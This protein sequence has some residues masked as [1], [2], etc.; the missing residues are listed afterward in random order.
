MSDE[1]RVVVDKAE[2]AIDNRA[3]LRRFGKYGMAASVAAASALMMI[4]LFARA[5]TPCLIGVV[6]PVVFFA[7]LVMFAVGMRS[8]AQ[9]A[10]PGVVS[11]I[12]DQV[13]IVRWR[14][15]TTIPISDLLHGYVE[16]NE[17]VLTRRGGDEITI[18]TPDAATAEALLA[19][20]G[21]RPSERVLR[22]PL[23][24]ASE[25]VLGS[26]ALGVISLLLLVPSFLFGAVV[27]GIGVQDMMRNFTSASF[28]GMSMISVTEVLLGA[29]I[30]AVAKLMSAR[31]AVVGTD[32]VAYERTFSRQFVPYS[33]IKAVEKDSQGVRLQ[34]EGGGSLLLPVTARG[35]RLRIDVPDEQLAGEEVRRRRVL[36]DRIAQARRTS[37]EKDA[38]RASLARLDR[39]GRAAD[40]WRDDLKK[41]LARG[42]E[43]R[44]APLTADDLGGV[45]EDASA[46]AERRVGAVIALG[47]T[48]KEEAKRRVRIVID[49][50]ADDDLRRALEAAAEGEIDET[51]IDRARIRVEGSRS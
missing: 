24:S 6:T 1:R 5:E 40:S 44:D 43:Y 31:T 17:V 14:R 39:N 26:S 47:E 42:P 36:C 35:K 51:A 18:A 13:R 11:V 25:T 46:S 12:G 49:A 30:L 7:S 50:S 22:V 16:G 34:T 45:I 21:L 9:N 8:R 29:A 28:I 2:I 19:A 38:A 48:S 41:V 4:A 10:A 15:T 20:T 37:A 33:R 23:A 32:G 27:T 3:S